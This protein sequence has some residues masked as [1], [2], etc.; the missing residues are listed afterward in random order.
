MARAP[1]PHLQ[2]VLHTFGVRWLQGDGQ[3]YSTNGLICSTGV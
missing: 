2:L 3:A 1:I